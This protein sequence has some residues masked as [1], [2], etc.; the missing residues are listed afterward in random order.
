VKLL[1]SP[2]GERRYESSDNRRGCRGFPIPVFQEFGVEMRL[3]PIWFVLALALLNLAAVHGGRVL[4]ALYALKLGAQPF[5]VGVLASAFSAVPLLLSWL[6][7][8]L[9][10]RFGSRWLLTFAG[11]GI[12]CGMLVPY[13]VPA[14]SALYIASAIMGMALT[15]Q[16]VST[17]NLIGSLGH[18]DQRARDFSNFAMVAAVATSVG[19]IVSGFS[20]DHMGF[21]YACLNL[22]ALALVSVVM[23]VIGGGVL[24][25]G[26]RHAAPSG[27]FKDML[28][29]RNVL[30]VLASSSLVM[31]GT[32]LFQFYLPIYGLGI[33][34]SA[35]AIGVI[36]GSFAVAAFAV[37]VILPRLIARFNEEMVLYYAFGIGAVGFALIPFFQNA[38]VLCGISFLL[39][40]GMGCGAPIT[41]MM[42][43]SQSPQGRS[44]EALG[45]R[46]TA[47]H[48]A[49]VVGPLVSGS[50][51]SVFGLI[52]VFLVNALMMVSGS[53]ISRSGASSRKSRVP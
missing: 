28:A 3:K 42:T 52:P 8:R 19:P 53:L 43:Y 51:G 18:A 34:L 17:Q 15:V 40:L 7:G 11:V 21:A 29:D 23:L 35:S 41:M 27:S 22:V 50:I 45:L 14:M 46:F 12:A 48:L 44:G 6:V 1:Q 38:I 13:L 24:P 39:G 20:I 32:D 10:D 37:R 5:A 30:R 36:L 26:N 2:G 25:G 4:L 47:N 9:V 16:A 49:R 31:L 33:G